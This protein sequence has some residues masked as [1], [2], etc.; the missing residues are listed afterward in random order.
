MKIFDAL[1]KTMKKKDNLSYEKFEYS[2]VRNTIENYCEKYLEGVDDIL[3]FEALPS[4]LDATLAALED[5]QFQE[6]YEF[7]QE[8]PTTFMVRLREFNLLD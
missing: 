2:N 1:S 5:T 8:T 4:A 7:A 3:V 6:K